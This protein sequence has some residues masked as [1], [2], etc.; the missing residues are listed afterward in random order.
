MNNFDAVDPAEHWKVVFKYIDKGKH[1]VAYRL[2]G[3]DFYRDYTHERVNKETAV[4]LEKYEQ[5]QSRGSFDLKDEHIG[6]NIGRSEVM[7]VN[8]GNTGPPGA[9]GTRGYQG[10][11]GG[12]GDQGDQ[13]DQGTQ[14]DRG[15]QG[16]QGIRGDRGR[17]GDQGI[18][19][20]RGEPGPAAKCEIM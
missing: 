12:Q 13:G 15:T 1:L 11:Q 10:Y 19:G 9:Q 2:A 5:R 16:D 8:T 20:I 3:E 17:Q 7:G 4:L 14:G 18:Q 6:V